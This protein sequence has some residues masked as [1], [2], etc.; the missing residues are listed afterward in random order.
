MGTQALWVHRGAPVLKAVGPDSTRLIA[1][2]ARRS[3]IHP[4]VSKDWK[5]NLKF[6]GQ[7]AEQ[8][9]PLHWMLWRNKVRE[10]ERGRMVLMVIKSWQLLMTPVCAPSYVTFRDLLIIP[11]AAHWA[12]IP[13]CLSQAVP[14]I[15]KFKQK[16]K[17]KKTKKT[18]F[19]CWQLLLSDS[20]LR[21]LFHLV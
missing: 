20:H 19:C 16:K 5:N 17:Q 13:H 11:A 7:K 14:Q 10:R 3:P 18:L 9:D 8:I 2:A 1:F 12:A 4:M 6:Q 21:Q 15:P